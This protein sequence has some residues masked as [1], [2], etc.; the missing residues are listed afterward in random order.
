[1]AGIG[2]HR[3]VLHFVEVL[4]GEHALIAGDGDKNIADLGGFGHGHDAEAVHHGFDGARGI[5]LG[6]D[7]VG[8]QTLGA[9]GETASA[10]AVAGDNHALAGEQN[11]RGAHDA[12][13][14]GLAGAVAI[15]EQSAW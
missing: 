7:H 4:G 11:I 1:V 13:K 10:P 6:D 15:I 14:R 12:V 3:A 2:E 9:H 5:D 8:A